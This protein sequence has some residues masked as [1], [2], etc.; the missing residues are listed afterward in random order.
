MSESPSDRQKLLQSWIE[1]VDPKFRPDTHWLLTHQVDSDPYWKWDKQPR[2]PNDF[3]GMKNERFSDCN[4][5]CR[6][7]AHCGMN[8]CGCR[9][10]SVRRAIYSCGHHKGKLMLLLLLLIVIGALVLNEEK[11]N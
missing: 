5:K 2:N 1:Q 10:S 9:C 7:C 6:S 4:C 11:A 8:M 3:A